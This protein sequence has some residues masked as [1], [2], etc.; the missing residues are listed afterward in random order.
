[1]YHGR[2]NEEVYIIVWIIKMKTTEKKLVLPVPE[3]L[4]E[5]TTVPLL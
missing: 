4:H 1:M 3:C 2:Q 5:I